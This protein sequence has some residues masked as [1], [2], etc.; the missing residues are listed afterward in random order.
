MTSIGH[1]VQGDSI[2][3]NNAKTFANYIKSKT[4]SHTGIGPLK[5]ADGHLITDDK[6]MAE[7]L[8]NFF[9][10]VFTNENI[11][12]IPTREQETNIEVESMSF[13]KNMIRDK[14]IKI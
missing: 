8:N 7:K 1:L 6:K 11:H 2:C 14:C 10:S 12:D 4:K 9:A 13:T 3:D 5:D